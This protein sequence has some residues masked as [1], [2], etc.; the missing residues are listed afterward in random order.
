MS[1]LPA[2]TA[3]HS[4]L[5]QNPRRSRS[6]SI[7]LRL[8]DWR[9]MK[10]E[11]PRLRKVAFW[12]GIVS[13]AVGVAFLSFGVWMTIHERAA[14]RDLESMVTELRKNGAIVENYY[15]VIKDEEP[16]TPPSLWNRYYL[17]AGIFVIAGAS[18][19]AVARKRARLQP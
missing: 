9:Q 2:I 7:D 5:P 13:I 3:C 16:H 12:G 6:L 19:I 1:G 8:N 14:Y 17:I 11:T 10:P 18:T 4:T 15:Q